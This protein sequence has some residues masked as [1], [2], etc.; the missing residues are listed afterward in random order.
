[1][2]LQMDHVDKNHNIDD[3]KYDGVGH[4]LFAKCK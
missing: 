4:L 2:R 1:M 3:I